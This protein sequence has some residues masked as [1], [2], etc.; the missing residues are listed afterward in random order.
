MHEPRKQTFIFSMSPNLFSDIPVSF[1][2]P[3]STVNAVE[4][5]TATFECEVNK[6]GD[7]LVII[8]CFPT[9]DAQIIHQYE[10]YR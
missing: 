5:E 10:I 2:H 9:S 3:L 8:S 1:V 7:P 6:S 4:N